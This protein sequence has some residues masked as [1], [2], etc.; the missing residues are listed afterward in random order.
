MYPTNVV[1][2]KNK[3]G[4]LCS[5]IV[6]VYCDY[7]KSWRQW[8]FVYGAKDTVITTAGFLVRV[9]ANFSTVVE[10]SNDEPYDTIMRELEILKAPDHYLTLVKLYR[11][12]H[13]TRRENYAKAELTHLAEKLPNFDALVTHPV[14][15]Q[16]YSLGYVVIALNDKYGWSRDQIADWVDSLHDGGILDLSFKDRSEETS[17]EDK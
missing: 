3:D 13:A 4:S 17:I 2:C 15:N 11:D 14:L 8:E 7:S 6:N 10:P 12:G 16:P 1:Y 5:A 9:I